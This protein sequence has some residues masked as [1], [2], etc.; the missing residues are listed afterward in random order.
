MCFV[1]LVLSPK[2]S[3][4]VCFREI[5]ELYPFSACGKKE[6]LKGFIL[7]WMGMNIFFAEKCSFGLLRTG[8]IWWMLFIG[9]FV[10]GEMS[11]Q[12]CLHC[13]PSRHWGL[14][15]KHTSGSESFALNHF[16]YPDQGWMC[17]QALSSQESSIT[18]KLPQACHLNLSG[19]HSAE[20][21]HLYQYDS[22]IIFKK[23]FGFTAVQEYQLFSL[24]YFWGHFKKEF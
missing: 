1:L 6:P 19:F 7:L 23:L 15:W 21:N 14:W 2:R 5:S 8:L 10:C 16:S 9:N 20:I 17:A 13:S 24:P 12:L 18:T 22:R 4:S 11:K 3:V